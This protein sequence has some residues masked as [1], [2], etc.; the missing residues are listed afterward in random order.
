MGGSGPVE[1]EQLERLRK[2]RRRSLRLAPYRGIRKPNV[3][4]A[5]SP[6]EFE[7]AFRLVH[8]VYVEMGYFDPHPSGLRVLLHQA[9]P[10][11]LVFLARDE[12]RVLGTVSL[13]M[14]GPMGLPMDDVYREELEPFRQQGR[15]IAEVSSLA[16][17][18]R[19][20]WMLIDEQGRRRGVFWL[21]HQAVLYWALRRQLHHLV[22]TVNPRHAVFYERLYLFQRFGPV[23]SYD[24][25][26]GAPAVPLQLDLTSLPERLDRAVR[27]S[28][29]MFDMATF[30]FRLEHGFFTG[31]EG[32][33]RMDA[34]TARWFVERSGVL[35]KAPQEMADAFAAA[36]G[37]RNIQEFLCEVPAREMAECSGSARP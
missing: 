25:V 36:H 17:D 9:V 10:G 22:I 3:K 21:L 13:I 1:P 37:F 35:A 28:E 23:K 18:S 31:Q 19:F 34:S 7:E 8:D 4:V 5:D 14:D 29:R 16:V 30:F 33:P 26:R 27:E 20:R 32:P 2:D 15:R 24:T 6:E 12:R 11:N